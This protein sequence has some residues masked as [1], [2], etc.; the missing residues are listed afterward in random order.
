MTKSKGV[1]FKHDR[2]LTLLEANQMTVP[3]LADKLDVTRQLVY[4]WVNGQSLP[5]IKALIRLCALFK[6]DMNFFFPSMRK[7]KLEAVMA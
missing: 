3:E 7:H 6:V 1:E 4:R 5:G 2:L